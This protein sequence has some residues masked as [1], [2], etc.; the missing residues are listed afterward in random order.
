MT[1]RGSRVSSALTLLLAGAIG[2]AAY[3]LGVLSATGQR[4]ENRVLDAADFSLAPP[5][6]L[7]YVSNTSVIIA[8]GV[9]CLIAWVRWGVGRAIQIFLAAVLAIVLSQ[10]L[11]LSVLDRPALVDVDA[12]NSFPSGHATVF[13]ALLAA[14][15]WAVPPSL[16]G[17]M[18]VL[19]TG[20]LSFAGV[21][22]LA[23][24]WHRPSDVIGAMA[25]VMASFALCAWIRP[26]RERRTE[27]RVSS[28]LSRGVLR[29]VV[30][31]GVSVAVVAFTFGL[32][33]AADA[34]DRAMLFAG[35]ASVVAMAAFLGLRMH[36][37]T[38]TT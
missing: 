22:I 36:A 31:I 20:I 14:A 7:E 15:V 34:G 28:R 38:R 3:V 4:L 11:K 25:L 2:V 27:T 37:L 9:C 26:L 12:A 33:G 19:W 16:R 6:P 13:A 32:A 35:E 18:S 24:G 5:G 17:F 30:L 23:Y 29:F 21:Q 1:S 8:L 10:L